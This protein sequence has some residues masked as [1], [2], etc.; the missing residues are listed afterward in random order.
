ML[1]LSEVIIVISKIN[2]Y[3]SKNENNELNPN[4]KRIGNKKFDDVEKVNV[5]ITNFKVEDH[6]LERLSYRK[7]K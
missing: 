1:T 3:N 5:A 4:I 7:T 6:Y 2:F